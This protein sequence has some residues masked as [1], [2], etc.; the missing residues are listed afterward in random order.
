MP[1]FVTAA[2]GEPHVTSTDT[3]HYNAGTLGPGCYVL[4]LRDRMAC[5]MVDSNTLRIL[6]GDAVVCGRQWAIEGDYE[7]LNIDNGVPGYN[8]IDLVVCRIEIGEKETIELKVYKGEE[9]T[10][11][12]VVPGHVTGDL[13]DGD[14]VCEMPICSVRIN[15]I[16]PQ[17]PEMLAKESIDIMA[18]L[19]ELRDYKSQND[20]AVATA[21]ATANGAVGVNSSQANAISSAVTRIVALESLVIQTGWVETG[22]M[23]AAGTKKV[24]VNFTTAYKN[25]PAVL[26]E[27]Q[28]TDPTGT[29][30]SVSA[31]KT[32][33]DITLRATGAWGLGGRWV[34]IGK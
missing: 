27:P 2:A 29:A 26:F 28:T 30:H 7:E 34:A 16:N 31:T 24:S 22:T 25:V 1:H 32:G 11:T 5:T 8:R 23:S 3:A 14:N 17:A 15:G 9:T 19:Q 6:A 21:Q 18:L 33:F 20:K 10:G 4:P 13:N 12:P